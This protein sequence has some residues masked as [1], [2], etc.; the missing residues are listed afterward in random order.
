VTG[1]QTCAL[2]ISAVL[3]ENGEEDDTKKEE[4]MNAIKK[5][6]G[7]K[8]HD[9]IL[10]SLGVDTRGMNPDA[11]KGA[12]KA[13]NMIAKKMPKRNVSGTKIMNMQRETNGAGGKQRHPLER[14]GFKV[15][16]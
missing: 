1:V 15:A 7:E 8:L 10:R 6:R 4:V 13:Q 3:N 16:K 12:F 11:K 2:P 14:L 5:A 9:L